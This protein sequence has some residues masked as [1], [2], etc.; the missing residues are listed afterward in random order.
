[1]I[2]KEAVQHKA[3]GIISQAAGELGY[4]AYVVGGYVRDIFLKRDSKDIDIVAVGNGIALAKKVAGLLGP[5]TKVSVFKNY[6]T[7][8]LHI[9]ELE[10]E[11]VGARR[12]SYNKDS[13][14]PV[15]EDGTLEDDQLRRDF[16]I[17]AL[18]ISLNKDTYGELVDPFNGL[19]HI[20]QEI[21]KT[22]LEP[23]KTF[24]DDPLRMMRAVRFATQLDFTI[25]DETYEALNKNAHRLKIVSRERIIDE[26]NKMIMAE[27][28]SRG[29]KLLL[30]T[31]LLEQFFPE[32]VNL[33]GVDKRKEQS[34]KDNFYHTIEVL[35]NVAQ[36]GGDLWVRWAA[37]LHDIGKPATKR[38]SKETGYTF[39]GHEVVGSKMIPG[40]FKRLKMPLNDKMKYVQKLVFLHLRPIALIEDHVTDSAV[41]RLLFE[42]GDNIED[43]MMLCKAD[44]TSKN[45]TKVIRYRNN[46][47]MVLQK[48]K[49]VE[50]QD[51]LRNWQPPISGEEIMDTF[52]LKPSR[53]VG[54]IKN[55][56][57]E[58]I[59]DGEIK[60]NY[61]EAYEFMLKKANEMG[62]APVKNK[63]KNNRSDAENA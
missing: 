15:V 4:P 26:L 3:F 2:L 59:L 30:N 39:H 7:A 40:I 9:G 20:N 12:E 49:E 19:E 23:G 29:F 33:R 56:I 53:Q 22:P 24:S 34:H 14:K 48:L 42:A 5:K 37:L 17:N 61:E 45:R 55:A 50:E 8:M 32:M 57:R 6:G 38:Y 47:D 44:I 16:T 11:F 25:E 31:G 62:L 51:R 10:I 36:Q 54:E 43:L 21:I 13:R 41:R 28:P 52:G 63:K 1:M 60:N 18:A 27:Q 35:D 46:F 58:A